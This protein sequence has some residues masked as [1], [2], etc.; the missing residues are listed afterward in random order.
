M[1]DI[2]LHK[3]GDEYHY[4]LSDDSSYIKEFIHECYSVFIVF[5]VPQYGGSEVTDSYHDTMKQAC[6]QLAI[7]SR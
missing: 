1:A 2:T 5:Y 3:I 4:E 6:E 7:I